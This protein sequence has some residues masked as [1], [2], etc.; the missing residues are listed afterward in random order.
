MLVKEILFF[1]SPVSRNSYST[2]ACS[3]I[4]TYSIGV[5]ILRIMYLLKGYEFLFSLDGMQ[6]KATKQERKGS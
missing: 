1:N 5:V 3:K 6:R 2:I 4:I